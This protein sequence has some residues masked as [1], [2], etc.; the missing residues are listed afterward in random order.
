MLA[1]WLASALW[2]GVLVALLWGFTADDSYIVYRYADHFSSGRGL[3]YNPAE[4]VSAL[5]SPLH[6][7][8]CSLLSLLPL[9]IVASNKIMA[10]VFISTTCTLA[11]RRLGYGSFRLFLVAGLVVGSPHVILW[12][13]GGLET[14][15]LLCLFMVLFWQHVAFRRTPSLRAALALSLTCGFCFLLRFDSILLTAPALVHSILQGRRSDLSLARASLAL[16]GP[17]LCVAASWLAF[18]HIYYHDIFPTSYYS[19]GLA[20][21]W[22]GVATNAI[23]IFQFLAVSGLGAVAA[24]ILLVLFIRRNGIIASTVRHWTCT[25]AG[26]LVG[27]VFSGVYALGM[28]TT[29]MMFSYRFLVPYLPLV[30]LLV[31]DLHPLTRR[32]RGGRF[33]PLAL[34][35]MGLGTLALQGAVLA[36][37]L[38]TSLNPGAVGEY[39]RVN[40]GQ[41]KQFL[42]VL[43]EQTL[44]IRDHWA[45][46]HSRTG[47]PTVYVFA[48]GVPG[49]RLPNA[50]IVDSSIISYRHC[51][52]DAPSGISRSADYVFATSRHGPLATQLGGLLGRLQRLDA[53]VR[54][55]SFDGAVE[56]F[57]VYFNPHPSSF[58]LPPYIDGPPA[59]SSGGGN[60]MQ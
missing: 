21:S 22:Y 57:V 9:S 53:S 24:V 49:H 7:L 45:R 10:L 1:L 8:L 19:K 36:A 31:I 17:A 34:L 20:F 5:T 40:L 13:V 48:A 2:G 56:E 51:F 28:V 46:Q 35:T 58:R 42:N 14:P 39:R 27:L 60:S 43:Q 52:R 16:V 50:R 54:F 41:Y 15:Y 12:T 11:C 25:H 4:H 29:H 3:V 55:V 37:L 26:L 44:C 23:Y 6:A 30:L 33:N 32:Q 18:S 38:S 59:G 47:G